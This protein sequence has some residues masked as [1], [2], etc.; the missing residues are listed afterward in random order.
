MARTGALPRGVAALALAVCLATTALLP[1]A[2]QVVGSHGSF[3]PAFFSA[4]LLLDLLSAGLLMTQHVAHGRP[5]TRPSP[6]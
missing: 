3:L 4:V 1:L 5:R 2:G 6:W